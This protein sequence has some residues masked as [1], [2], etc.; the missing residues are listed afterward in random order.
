MNIGNFTNRLRS[1]LSL[2]CVRRVCFLFPAVSPSSTSL[3]ADSY[4]SF[5]TQP[6]PP[7][8]RNHCCTLPCNPPVWIRPF[9]S[10]PPVLALCLSPKGYVC[11]GLPHQTRHFTSMCQY[12]KY[13]CSHSVS[14]CSFAPSFVP[15]ILSSLKDPRATWSSS[16]VSRCLGA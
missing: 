4:L 12:G 15:R 8:P 7:L 11:V 16:T 6:T 13:A 1:E 5:K 2:P 9:S 10:V 14:H 3:P